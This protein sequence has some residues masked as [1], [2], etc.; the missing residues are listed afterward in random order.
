MT[1]SISE[2]II[3]SSGSS[4]IVLNSVLL[5]LP[6]AISVFLSIGEEKC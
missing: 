4:G 6:L 5:M 2:N 3:N 1:G